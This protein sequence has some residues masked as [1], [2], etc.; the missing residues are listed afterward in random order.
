MMVNGKAII[1]NK[2]E[3]AKEKK[4]AIRVKTPPITPPPVPFLI[5]DNAKANVATEKMK[6]K[7]AIIDKM[8]IAMKYL[9][10]FF[11][12]REY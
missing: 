6:N 2:V 9:T 10:L 8:V 4:Q 3:I 12:T 11:T 7:N 1:A 5:I